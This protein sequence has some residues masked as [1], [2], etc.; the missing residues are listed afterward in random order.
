MEKE[1]DKPGTIEAL[2]GKFDVGIPDMNIF[3][4]FPLHVAHKDDN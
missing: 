3:N 2:D 4:E 1:D